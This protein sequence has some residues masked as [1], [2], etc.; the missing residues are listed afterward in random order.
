VHVEITRILTAWVKDD[1]YGVN[2]LL[3]QLPRKKSVAGTSQDEKPKAVTFYN[4]VDYDIVEVGGINP[5][6]TPALVIVCDSN[7]RTVDI[8]N[9]N[10]SGHKMDEGWVAAFG[11]YGDQGDR[12]SAIRHGN[13]VLRAVKMCLTR[14]NK[15][16]RGERQ[17]LNGVV[18]GRVDRVEFQRA[19]GAVPGSTFLGLL[20]ADLTVLDTAP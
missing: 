4:D 18:L 20:F 16:C 5:P 3:A 12:A 7:P 9:P 13:Y 11:Y 17:R 6:T 15:Y 14:Y 8:Q 19:A 10:A 1:Q 2:A